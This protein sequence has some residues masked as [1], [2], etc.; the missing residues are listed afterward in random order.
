MAS[1]AA[2]AGIDNS[3]RVTATA[4]GGASVSATSNTVTLTLIE[5]AEL[6]T[7]VAPV[8]PQP[9]PGGSLSYEIR[10]TNGGPADAV[11]IVL[12]A[13]LPDSVALGDVRASEGAFDRVVGRWSIERLAVGATA[14][15]ALDGRLG[16]VAAGTGITLAVAPA[17]ARNPDPSADGD[18]SVASFVARRR[19]ITAA[20]DVVE[21]PVDSALAATRSIN[22]FAN[23]RLEGLSVDASTVTITA[24]GPLPAGFSLSDEGWVDLARY[25]P[26]G[27]VRFGYRMCERA[28]TGNC[29][30]AE[31]VLTV[32]RT[33]PVVAG[34]VFDDIDGNGRLDDDDP[35]RP[36]ID[37]VLTDGTGTPLAMSRTDE[38]GQYQFAGFD[39]GQYAMHIANPTSGV[40]MAWIAP[41]AIAPD[42]ADFD[43]NIA[44]SPMGIVYDATN[45]APVSGARIGVLSEEGAALPDACLLPGQQGQ[46]T[47]A[48]GRY[49]IA[50]AHGRAAA[51]PLERAVYRLRVDAPAGYRPP[52][53]ADLTPAPAPL[54]AGL[55]PADAIAGG[56]CQP[57]ADAAPAPDATAGIYHLALS[58]AAGDPPITRNHV[59]LMPMVPT[60]EPTDGPTRARIGAAECPVVSGRVFS[61]L[62]GNGQ[63]DPH[64][65][66]IA[67]VGVSIDD[68]MERT[69]AAGRYVIGCAGR[70]SGVGPIIVRLSEADLGG[71]LRATDGAERL[72]APAP[73][74]TA[75]VDFAVT[76]L[77]IVNLDLTGAVFAPGA[78][79]LLPATRNGIVAIALSAVG[80]PSVLRMTYFLRDETEDLA[81]ARIDAVAAILADEWAR[82]S[83]PP[84][85]VETRLV[86]V[87]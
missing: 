18:V 87:N 17:R 5:P 36:D 85:R 26:P 58:L 25:A 16:D 37:V 27:D 86:P 42:A 70:S 63:R 74:D 62:N 8:G 80:G 29:S 12:D 45:G 31:V 41:R 39:A 30:R 6:V 48:D 68:A 21:E 49:H 79:D 35:G 28:D 9:A 66:G 57:S 13:V 43:R 65:P 15:L 55:C 22:L 2:A 7:V 46:V 51:C 1:I 64:E 52:P 61:D 59:P 34:I 83:L 4:P 81:R 38:T 77:R 78:A 47:G 71:D 76:A 75:R 72:I 19:L 24:D 69:D 56:P 53:L 33:L 54:D 67:N 32:V 10:V 50:V 82:R 40:G 60:D 14:T 23:D 84:A 20:D 3:A 44:A 11:G 73:G